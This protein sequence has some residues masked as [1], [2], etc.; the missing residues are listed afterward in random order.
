ME[1]RAHAR[2]RTSVR[3]AIFAQGAEPSHPKAE[4]ERYIVGGRG[5][6]AAG[7]SA[8]FGLVQRKP[9]IATFSKT[10]LCYVF[11]MI[12]SIFKLVPIQLAWLTSLA[13]FCLVK[14]GIG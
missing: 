11:A 14:K 10:S 7:L 9:N 8:I 1:R 13:E 12:S 2:A 3:D 6:N 4:K 5:V